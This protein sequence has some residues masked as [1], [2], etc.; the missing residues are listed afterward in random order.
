MA[1]PIAIRL[2][3][4]SVIAGSPTFVQEISINAW[5]FPGA[6]PRYDI[7]RDAHHLIVSHGVFLSMI[8][9]QCACLPDRIVDRCQNHQFLLSLR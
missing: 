2:A 3:C 1:P 4:N 5:G 8:A 7:V 6:I 9:A